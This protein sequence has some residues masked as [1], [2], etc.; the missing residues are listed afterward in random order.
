M[1]GAA[2]IDVIEKGT[3]ARSFLRQM[4]ISSF[5]D[6]GLTE[7]A[8]NRPHEIWTEGAQGWERHDAP[9]CTLDACFKLANA[10]TVAR[11]GKLSTK[12]PIHP[13]VLPDGE[14]GHVLIAPACARDTIS[15]TIRIPSKVRFS[16]GEYAANG[17]FSDWRDVSPRRDAS[18]HYTLQP[19]ELEMLEA[20]RARDVVRMLELAVAN[21][22]NI[23]IGGGTGSGKTTLHKGLVD[24][25]PSDERIGTIEDIPELS[26]PNHPNNVPMFFSDDLPA[27]EL[28]RS[29]L[30]M[31]FDRVFMAE[32]RGDE[33]WD[34]ITL[35]NT[36]TPGGITTLHCNGARTAHPRIATLIKQG[37]VGQTLDW[38]FIMGQVRST[39]DLVL[40]M[41]RK[42][43]AELWYDP[44]GKWQWLDGAS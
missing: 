29:T 25:V 21:R 4:G 1:N 11:G 8:I 19:F 18:G 37:V 31:K 43:L 10:L 16:V 6:R 2:V 33:A 40:Y 14:R 39:I 5:F 13:V 42:R 35:M 32:L 3:I 26:L 28:V 7:V 15:I 38:Q 17:W 12:E 23:L 44:V 30:R 34:Y 27:K 24:L 9:A 20:Q 41:R 36:D 22:L